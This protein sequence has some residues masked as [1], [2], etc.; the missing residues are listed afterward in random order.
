MYVCMYPYLVVTAASMVT[1]I[2]SL[3]PLHTQHEYELYIAGRKATA[4]HLGGYS[5][6]TF[7]SYRRWI[8]DR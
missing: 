6:L 1:W 3:T 8:L 7:W 4:I 5:D 2:H